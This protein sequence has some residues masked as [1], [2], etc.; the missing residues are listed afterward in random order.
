MASEQD[1]RMGVL[2]LRVRTPLASKGA[3]FQE[4]GGPDAGAI[5]NAVPLN[6]EYHPLCTVVG[7]DTWMT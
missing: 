7:I 4:D 3:S 6:A 1:F 5:L 2:G